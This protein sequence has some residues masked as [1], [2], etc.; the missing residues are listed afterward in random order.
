MPP[1]GD[2]DGGA[3]FSPTTRDRALKLCQRVDT[4]NDGAIDRQELAAALREVFPNCTAEDVD[5]LMSAVD[6]NSDGVVQYREFIRW[7]ELPASQRF[8]FADQFKQLCEEI[9]A[10]TPGSKTLSGFELDEPEFIGGFTHPLLEKFQICDVDAANEASAPPGVVLVGAQAFRPRGRGDEPPPLELV[11]QRTGHYNI[12]V[13]YTFLVREGSI[14][15]DI[16]LAKL[17]GVSRALRMALEAFC[18]AQTPQPLTGIRLAPLP[19]LDDRGNAVG[20]S[21]DIFWSALALALVRLSGPQLEK[22]SQVSLEAAVGTPGADLQAARVRLVTTAPAEGE[23]GFLLQPSNGSMEWV[24]KDN[25]ATSRLRRLAAFFV[26]QRCVWSGGYAHHGASVSLASVQALLAGTKVVRASPAVGVGGGAAARL[27]TSDELSDVIGNAGRTVMGVARALSLQGRRVAA[28][29]AASA[30]QVGGGA[31]SGGRHALEEAWCLS[32]T[33]YSSLQTLDATSTAQHI[34]DDS[35]ILSPAVDIFRAQTDEG[36]QLLPTPVPLAGVISVAMFNRN[37]SITDSPLDSPADP[38]T[39]VEK[40][41]ARL[42]SV[43]AASRELNAEVLVVPDVG[44]GVFRND[45]ALVGGCFGAI[46]ASESSHLQQVVLVS[47]NGRF[48]EA[49]Q[50]TF[51]G[52]DPRPPCS[53]GSSCPQLRE[54]G[55]AARL[56]HAGAG[57]KESLVD[58]LI[59]IA[60]NQEPPARPPCRYGSYCHITSREHLGRFSH[61][62]GSAAYQAT[63]ASGLIQGQNLGMKNRN[64][65]LQAPVAVIPHSGA[66][67]QPHSPTRGGGVPAPPAATVPRPASAAPLVAKPV[68]RYGVE[69]YSK[70]PKHFEEYDHPW[71]DKAETTEEKRLRELTQTT[72]ELLNRAKDMNWDSVKADVRA[73][74]ELINMRPETRQFALIH[75]AAY[76]VRKAELEWLLGRGADLSLR[77]RDGRNVEEVLHEGIRANPPQTAAHKQYDD[78]LAAYMRQKMQALATGGAAAIARGRAATEAGLSPTAASGKPAGAVFVRS[79]RRD[80]EGTYEALPPHNGKTA[81]R[82]MSSAGPERYLL[83]HG[84]MYRGIRLG[85]VFDE[86]P[87]GSERPL[88]YLRASYMDSDV[89]SRRMNEYW[90]VWN[91]SRVTPPGDFRP[92]A[93]MSVT[94]RLD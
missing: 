84:G 34:P 89:T 26:T 35:C 1:T 74:P 63:L 87:V 69:C 44:C 60:R 54:P 76:Q 7:L 12:S 61:P 33:L 8:C 70:N 93:T 11:Q 25:D 41:R 64:P 36:Y 21:L 91:S 79:A 22:L 46:L 50:R 78:D 81:Y 90:R 73:R 45:P 38:A 72:H 4:D 65:R 15:E 14:G 28:V 5:G 24:R 52:A 68:C 27:V 19:L 10:T 13:P 3:I 6:L 53:L 37:P 86:S 94:K 29:S 58:I 42:R 55:H 62:E 67:A 31:S 9:T 39:Y 30:Y 47:A 18:T 43:V 71:R 80:L 32:S 40:T 77:T 59:A 16:L 49:C 88:A 23:R 2:I 83:Y 17:D 75:Y 82:M 85:W 48:V 20:Y 51:L 66:T 57:G 56:E 92:D